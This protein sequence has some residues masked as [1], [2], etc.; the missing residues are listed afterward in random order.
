MLDNSNRMLFFF[1]RILFFNLRNV[2]VY[3]YYL[4]DISLE[5]CDYYTRLVNA[6]GTRSSGLFSCNLFSFLFSFFYFYINR[7]QKLDALTKTDSPAIMMSIHGTVST[8]EQSKWIDYD[9]DPWH[10]IRNGNVTSAG[11][12]RGARSINRTYAAP[13]LILSANKLMIFPP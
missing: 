10:S 9:F 2:N 6:I 1:I 8:L 4:I 11:N 7:L 5:I 13:K 3:I 12:T